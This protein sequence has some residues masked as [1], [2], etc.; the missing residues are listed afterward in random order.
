MFR[1]HYLAS[2]ALAALLAAPGAA[3]AQSNSAPSTTVTP[4][5]PA[6]A[7][8]P[9]AARNVPGNNVEQRVE[10]HIRDLHAQLRITSAEQSPWQNFA[11]IMRQNARD[12]DQQFA[13]RM[14]QFGTMNA[15]QNMQSYQR[16]A[17]AHAQNLQRLV[18]A[19]EK[20]YNAMPED[21]RHLTDQ[22]FR[23]NAEAHAQRRMQTGSNSKR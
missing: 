19:F 15:L 12:M 20:L 9:M 10:E 3:L 23:A 17:E 11:D 2:V 16:I 14:D 4:P 21:Q 22:V 6:E 8:S 1:S 7:A 5:A 18:P 13:A